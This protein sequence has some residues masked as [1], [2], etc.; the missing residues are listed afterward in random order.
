MAMWIPTA[1]QCGCEEAEKERVRAAAEERRRSDEMLR[2][3]AELRMQRRINGIFRNSGIKG[4]WVN[5]TFDSFQLDDN[6]RSAFEKVKR[7]ADSFSSD[8]L[9]EVRDERHIIPPKKERNGLFITGSYGTGKTHLAAALANQLIGQGIPVICMTMVDLLSRI[10]ESFD[11]RDR[12][13]EEEILRTYVSC[14]LLVIDDL[15][16]E[17][18]T[19]WGINQIFRIINARYEAYMPIVI[20]TNYS[21]GELVERMTLEE[22]GRGT[23]YDKK[24]AEK[25]LDR[26]QGVCIGINMEWPSWRLR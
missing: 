25:T 19:E 6:N 21:G 20:T 5:Q 16:S 15:G 18:P 2:R 7:Y 17:Q 26:L 10:R 24:T 4:R 13:S 3:E 8:M 23:L 9:P 11:R 12:F 14:P 1:E 22:R